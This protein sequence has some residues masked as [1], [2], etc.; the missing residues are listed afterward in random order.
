[1]GNGEKIDLALMYVLH[2]SKGEV[3]ESTA[4]ERKIRFSGGTASDER[5]FR[6]WRTDISSGGQKSSRKKRR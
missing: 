2:M 3:N 1:M 4:R 5:I 6:L